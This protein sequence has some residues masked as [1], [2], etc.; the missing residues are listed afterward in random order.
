MHLYYMQN[1]IK[2]KLKKNVNSESFWEVYF[3]QYKLNV[4]TQV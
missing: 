3:T 4:N 2:Y 1:N